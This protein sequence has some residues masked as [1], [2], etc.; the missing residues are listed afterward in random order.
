M[1]V[2]VPLWSGPNDG[3]KTRRLQIRLDWGRLRRRLASKRVVLTAAATLLVFFELQTDWLQSRIGAY[4][5]SAIRFE[6]S[7]GAAGALPVAPSGPYDARLGYTGLP[8][9]LGR[10]RGNY[11]IVEQARSSRPLV[12]LSRWGA[13][14]V[15]E[16]KSQAGLTILDRKAAP[17][18]TARFPRAVYGTY[19]A[20]PPVVVGSLLYIEN[21]KILDDSSPYRNPAVEWNRLAK[22]AGDLALKKI[23]PRHPLSGGSTL[24]TQL[25]KLRHSEGGRTASTVEKF[26]Q[27]MAATFRAYRKGEDTTVVRREIVRDYLNSFPL[28]AVAGYGEVAGLRE[29]LLAWFGESPDAVDGLLARAGDERVS[30]EMRARQAAAYRRALGLLLALN[31][32]AYYLSEG[33]LP[34][35]EQRIDGYLRLFAKEGVIPQ[36]LAAAALLERLPVPGSGALLARGAS[37]LPK[38]TQALRN[39]LLATL[40]IK[41]LYDLDRL[42]LT[43]TTTFDAAMQSEISKELRRLAEPE[44]AARAGLFGEKLLRPKQAGSAILSFTLHERTE[45]A[46]VVRAEA[47]NYDSPLSINRGT[48]LE[49]GSTAKLRTLVTYLEVITNLYQ[50]HKGRP[51]A[52]QRAKARDNLTAWVLEYLQKQPDAPLAAILDAAM[53]RR[54]SA[55]P[56]ERFFTGGGV[57]TFNNFD[58]S[59]NGS[60]YSV[61]TALENS[62]NLVFVR[63]MRDLEQYYLWRLPGELPGMLD[64]PADP[65]RKQYLDRFVDE[66][67]AVFLSKYWKEYSETSP[68]A[69][70]DLLAE[71]ARGN[72]RRLAILYRAVNE[73]ARADDWAAFLRKHGGTGAAGQDYYA[74]YDMARFGWGDRGYLA[75]LHPLELWV[76]HYRLR[77]PEASYAEA[78]AASAGV[79]REVYEWLYKPAKIRGQNTRILTMLQREAFQGIFESWKRQGYPFGDMVP[80]YASALG[81]SGDSPNALAE[82]AGIIVNGGVRKPQLR[83]KSMRFAAGTPYETLLRRNAE[84]EERIYPTELASVVQRSLFGVVEKGTARRVAGLF[85]DPALR[86]G[87]KTGTGDNR[88]WMY[89][90]GGAVRGS[91]VLNRT[92]TFVF[93]LGDRYYGTVTAFVDGSEAAAYSFTSSLPVQILRHLAPQL[94][95][96]MQKHRHADSVGESLPKL[97]QGGR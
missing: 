75:G 76:V 10:L 95:M 52:E 19:E 44:H 74:K 14:P 79:R 2:L 40:G 73:D 91:R 97:A 1:T 71:K 70:L 29:G 94:A 31:R 35:L 23:D 45:G 51:I 30:P 55:S 68:A 77:H 26:Q 53:Q 6:R 41:G 85:A 60:Y 93:I 21:R 38:G 67:S 15:F 57:H 32:P 54:Y 4:A 86:I 49:L 27:M 50:E 37:A 43:V 72:G 88:V 87:G 11:E 13:Y 96:G 7:S 48:R 12:V 39:D 17:L 82:L 80:S 63:L 61:E 62:I 22:A 64:N 36:E 34:A 83:V 5:A 81:S 59:H 18:F 9:M 28:G 47:D 90:A 16:E 56:G 3:W 46:N 8:E 89:S 84:T 78:L 20:I 69:A 33:G 24:A 65:R 42:D 92:A 66:E 58:S 25:E